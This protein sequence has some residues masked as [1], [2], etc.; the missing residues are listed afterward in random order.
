MLVTRENG[1][2]QLHAVNYGLN[3]FVARVQLNE[4]ISCTTEDQFC[5]QTGQHKYL[6]I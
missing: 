3:Q 2:Y 4:I 1:T 5:P 6:D